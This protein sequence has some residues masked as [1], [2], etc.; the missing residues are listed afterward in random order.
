MLPFL[1]LKSQSGH[2]RKARKTKYSPEVGGELALEER[3]RGQ[4]PKKPFP[5]LTSVATC[6]IL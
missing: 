3:V 1:G 2:Q 6:G 4:P 5:L